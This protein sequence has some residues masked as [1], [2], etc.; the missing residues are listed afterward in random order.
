MLN[1]TAESALNYTGCLSYGTG[2]V[3]LL[4]RMIYQKARGP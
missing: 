3:P 4:L 2:P 1:L